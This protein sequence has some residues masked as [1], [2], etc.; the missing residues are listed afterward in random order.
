M[1][2]VQTVTLLLAAKPSCDPTFDKIMA[3][4]LKN[5]WDGKKKRVENSKMANS[6]DLYR[7]FSLD[8]L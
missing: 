2:E 1:Q 3:N 4:N 7:V 8:I 5:A 6:E